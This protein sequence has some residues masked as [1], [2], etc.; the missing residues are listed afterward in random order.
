MI[1]FYQDSRSYFFI[2]VSN[3]DVKKHSLCNS[4]K[5]LMNNVPSK[6]KIAN[7]LFLFQNVLILKIFYFFFDEL[8][9]YVK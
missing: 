1:Y 4:D 6:I 9:I 7:T 2:R 8:D 3:I 5:I